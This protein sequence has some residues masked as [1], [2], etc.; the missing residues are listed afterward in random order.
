MVKSAFN[1]GTDATAI[2]SRERTDSTSSI[3]S[4][5]AGAPAGLRDFQGLAAYGLLDHAAKLVPRRNALVFGDQSFC[6]EELYQKTIDVAATLQR[7]GLQPGDRV[8]ILLPNVPEYVIALNAVWRA[9][10]VAV[11]IS[12]L[13]VADEV[14]ALVSKTN[15]SLVITLDLLSGLTS[16]SDADLLLVSLRDH[17]PSWARLAYRWELHKRTGQWSIPDDTRHRWLWDEVTG[18]KQPFQSVEFDPASTPAYILPTGGTTGSPK[19]V[20]LS[21][22]NLVANAWQQYLWTRRSFAN[23]TMLA[24]LPF[25]HS[26]GLS[27]TVMTGAATASTLVLHHRFE[28]HAVARLIERHQ[29]T[30]FHAV[31]AMLSALNVHY[32]AYPR[33]APKRVGALKWVISGGASLPA[34]VALEFAEHSGA[35]V[36]EGYGLSEASPV[37]HVGHLF[38]EGVPGNIG[39]PLPQTRCQLVDPTDGYSPVG[40]GVTGELWVA[41]PQVMMGYLDDPDSTAEVKRGEWLRTGDLAVRDR[42]GR[43]AIVGR[44]KDLIITS[45]FNVY[46]RDVET[47]LMQVRGVADVAVVG[48]PDAKRGEVVK[49]FIVVEKGSTFDEAAYRQHCAST[50][51]KHKRPVVYEACEG[52][53]PKNFLGK[54]L[55]R[56][57]REREL[58][59]EPEVAA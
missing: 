15:C 2:E 46:P 37:T 33:R 13:M 16:T 23:E 27:A 22:Q 44:M 34:E 50:L 40:E 20:V 59:V 6:Y 43:Y 14:A 56:Q 3:D 21:H 10:G 31:P 25:F 58:T 8:G 1:V 26:Y 19:A 32:R 28:T 48:L 54:V 4:V 45:G 9:G 17:L 11:A 39:Y 36:V 18:T 35:C 57:L 47:A 51:S 38:R 41:G 53:L 7:L 5:A 12:P 52:E 30:V 29:P 49:A 55:R 42:N 24:V